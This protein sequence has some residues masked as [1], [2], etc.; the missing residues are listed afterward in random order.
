MTEA[1]LRDKP[2]PISVK[3]SILQDRKSF[4]TYNIARLRELIRY[5]PDEKLEL[6]HVVP[7]LLHVNSPD[8]PGYVNR[9][10]TPYGVYQFYDSGFWRLAEKRPEIKRKRLAFLTSKSFCIKGVYLMGSTGTIGQTGYSDFDYWVVID[11]RSFSKGQRELLGKKLSRIKNWGKEAYGHDLTLFV[12]DLEQ[13]RKNDFSGIHG[14]DGGP[15]QKSLLKEEFYRSFIMIAGQIPYWAVLPPGLSDDDYTSWVRTAS[16][17]ADREFVPDDYVDLGNLGSIRSQ[18]CPDA[19]L[20]Q[21]CKAQKDPAKALIKASVIAH[22][23]SFQHPDGLLCNII[24]ERFPEKNLDS[25]FLDPYVLA[26]ERA[27]SFYQTIH[28]KDGLDL[29][30]QCIYLRLIGYLVPSPLDDDNPKRKVLRRLAKAWSWAR[31][32]VDRLESYTSWTE[33]E[34]LK[35][36]DRIFDK[37]SSLYEL[38]LHSQ[39]KPQP[40]IDLPARSSTGLSSASAMPSK[41]NLAK[42]PRCSAYLRAQEEPASLFVT[43]Q[44]HKPGHDSW[45]VHSHKAWGL[46]NDKSALFVARE[47]LHILGW[48]ICNGLYK[49]GSSRIVFQDV[50]NLALQSSA[51]R[52]LQELLCFFFNET[53]HIKYRRSDPLWLKVFVTSNVGFF[54]DDNTLRRAD[55]L[56]QNTWGEMFFYSYSLKRVENNLL[57]CYK[58]G[59]KVWHYLKKAVP[60]ESEYRVYGSRTIRGDSTV[61][62]IEDFVES[63]RKSDQKSVKPRVAA[64]KQ[65]FQQ[66][67]KGPLLDL[68]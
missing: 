30:R 54:P 55:F 46:L 14:K 8:W 26:F 40:L 6:F 7:L 15:T 32:Q 2:D 3:R 43:R 39:E 22:H 27:A 41:M 62:T 61:K 9:P 60:G 1:F 59:R 21:I 65:Q 23:Y 34:K 36:E 37:L 31:K 44:E 35:L 19:V 16:L 11:A 5:L 58:I 13:V 50:E 28:D 10:Q 56:V 17:S 66:E 4:I 24:K 68:F 52:L 18:E 12:L 49:S 57:K 53:P 25:Y 64:V 47:L 38:I 48:I 29:V 63:F 51:Q 33:G 45:A 67:G 42:I 20:W